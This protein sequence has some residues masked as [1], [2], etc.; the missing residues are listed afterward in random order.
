MESEKGNFMQSLDGRWEI[1]R[2][3]GNRGRE[4]RWFERGGMSDADE[5]VVPGIMQQ[6]FP[7]CHGVFW[8]W[9]NF[10]PSI[11]AFP[12][13]RYL[14]RFWAV[15]YL[16][17]VWLNGVHVGS[18]EGGETP[19]VLDITNTLKPE[20][21]NRLVVRVLNPTDEPID[22]IKLRQ[23]AQCC[24]RVPYHTGADYD[25]AGIWQSVEL[26]SVP[27]PWITNIYVRADTSTGI[28]HIESIVLN[29]TGTTKRGYIEVSIAPA[30]GG[31]SVE[32]VRSDIEIAAGEVV[33]KSEPRIAKPHLWSTDAPYLY[34]VTVKL[35]IDEWS[36]GHEVSVRCGF[37]DFCFRDGYFRLNGRRIFLRSAL[38][39]NTFPIGLHIPHDQKLLYQEL[40]YAKAMGFNMLRFIAGMATPAHLDICDELGLLIQEESMA[41]WFLGVDVIPRFVDYWSTEDSPKLAER[42]DLSTK[43]MILRDRNHPSIVI[44]GFLN[45]TRYG[46]YFRHA[47]NALQ[48]VRSMD[49][50]RV[51]LLSSGRWDRKLSIG[52]ISNP[53]SKTWDY[54]LGG[55]DPYAS[56]NKTGDSV[57]IL[58]AGDVHYYPSIPLLPDSIQVLR[59]MGQ[60]TKPVLLSEHGNGSQVDV[61]RVVRFFEQTGVRKDLEDYLI[62]QSWAEKYLADWKRFGIDTVFANPSEL[63]LEGQRIHS[64]QRLISI[65]AIRSNPNIC[66]YH[67]T[68][69]TDMMTG[70]GCACTTFRELKPGIVDAI[71]DGWASLRWCLFVEPVHGY[72]GQKFKLEAVLANEDALQAGEYPVRFKIF[73]PS[74]TVWEKAAILKLADTQGANEPSLVLPVLSEEVELDVP[75]GEYK[76]LAF[77]EQGAAPAGGQVKFFLTD[78]ADFPQVDAEVTVWGN[79]DLLAGWLQDRGIRYRRF[80]ELAP[81]KREIILVGG[82]D[83]MSGDLAEWQDLVQR[84]SR[85][86]A[87]IFLTPNALKRGSDP[88]GWLP[89]EKKG[90]LTRIQGSAFGRD[91]FVKDHPIFNDLPRGRGLLDLTFY[92]DLIPPYIFDGQDMPEELV[93]GAFAIGYGDV[94]D[95]PPGGY[96]SGMHIAVYTLGAGRFIIN[97]LLILENLRKHPAAD[98]LFLNFMR[99]AARYT[100][101]PLLPFSSESRKK[102]SIIYPK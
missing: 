26:L 30:S 45:E 12:D 6:T 37:R 63:M 87:A 9:R 52:S 74:G 71:R 91:D 41:G 43:E 85:G 69:L 77:F 62:Y 19:F 8:Y 46:Q 10:T 3:P 94:P 84:I 100:N 70:C 42:F 98:R 86:S 25:W 58:G 72:R 81:D 34:R 101:K 48:L 14:L 36:N 39:Y 80:T 2:D 92:R 16:A 76:F 24:K 73:G 89:L 75:S 59:T 57:Y 66:G 18:H 99:Y 17:D 7:R 21:E 27:D 50:T 40:Y 1:A 5:C 13:G 44:W 102:L 93:A 54:L 47:V 49:N 35:K 31:S 68:M 22:G 79:E 11:A 29:K 60:G 82:I 64:E 88:L 33:L 51:V 4:E 38:I 90:S 53:G 15:D 23:V 96:Y 20:V 61:I 97:S 67:I 83:G 95:H 28:I 55:E 65:N 78:P 32:T 56:D